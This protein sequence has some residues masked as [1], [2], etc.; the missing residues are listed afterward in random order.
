M[1]PYEEKTD[2]L[3]INYTEDSTNK[4]PEKKLTSQQEK[5]E[6][7]PEKKET[8]I[9]FFNTEKPKTIEIQK[10]PEQKKITTVDQNKT[11]PTPPSKTTPITY[12]TPKE[13]G[14]EK[15]SKKEEETPRVTKSKDE[16]TKL[17]I[18]I[19]DI[20]TKEQVAKAS[21]LPIEVTLAFIPPKLEGEKSL[22]GNN[23]RSPMIH[24]PLEATSKTHNTKETLM[25]GDSYEKIEQR[26]ETIRNSYPTIR[27]LNNHTGSRF[28][29]DSES[30]D[31]L[32][33]ALKKHNFIFVDSRT[34]GATVAK[35]ITQKYGMRYIGRN[36]F[37]DNDPTQGAILAQLKEA[38][39]L[40]RK[41]GSAIA[42]GHPH[43]ATFSVLKNNQHLFENI[44]V[45]TIDKI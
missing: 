40:A 7:I 41:N 33:R 42:I 16:K 38:I 29:Q 18:I 17:V 5:I 28:T 21:N 6:K 35:S 2:A 27:Y 34:S 25:V 4:E 20:T 32:I 30:M 10:Q 8:N 43:S 9:S 24:L 45:V 26:I 22:L 36:V 14:I 1:I 37:L 31:R 13:K 23:F 12:E 39:A 44:D 19:D 15:I 3:H 11:K